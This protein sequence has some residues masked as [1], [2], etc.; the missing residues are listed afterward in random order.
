[1]KCLAVLPFL[2]FLIGA[3]ILLCQSTDATISGIVFDPSSRAISNAQVLILNEATGVRYSGT[4]NTVGLYTVSILPPGQYRIQVSKDG[5][6]TIIKP[7][8]I[9]NVQ[10]AVVLNFTLPVGATSESITVD[11][12]TSLLNTTD[13]SVSTVVD[14]QFVENIPLNGRSFQDLISMAPGVVTQ[15]PQSGSTLGANGDFSVNGQRTESNNYMVDGVTG[16]T[17]PG[18]GYGGYGAGTSGSLGGATALGTTQ[19]LISVDGLQEFRVQTST[20]SAEF[21]R[22]P[23]GQFSLV[24]R[25]GSEEFHGEVFDYLRNNFFD[26][27]DWFNDH[28]GDPI[29]A[30]R[31]NDFGGTF[32]G[33]IQIGRKYKANQSFFFVSYEGLRLTQP[34]AATIQYVP[35]LFMR[36]QSPSSMQGILN[37]FPIPN[38]ADYGDSANPSLAEFIEAYSSPSSID[39]TSLRIDHAFGPAFSV[40]GRMG[41]TPSM[42]SSRNDF[43][44]NTTQ[45]RVTTATFGVTNQFT[46]QISNEFRLGYNSAKSAVTDQ[47][48]TFGGATPTNLASA[49]GAGAVSRP[50]SLVELSIA[51]VGTTNLIAA[52]DVHNQGEQWNLVDTFRLHTGHQQFAFGVDYRRIASPSFPPNVQTA[53]FFSDESVL[54]STA[55]LLIA[56]NFFPASP[57]FKELSLFAQDEWRPTSRLSLSLGLRW[58]LNPPP[59]EAHGNDAYTLLGSVYEPTSLELAP[60]GTPL[61]KTTWYNLAPRLGLAWTVRQTPGRETVLRTGG[62]VF[63]DTNNQVAANGY[64]GIGFEASG[65]NFAAL[66]PVPAATFSQTPTTTAPYASD[67]IYAFPAHL[68]LPYTL[69][70]NA[71]LEQ[72]LGKHNAMTLSYIG[73]NGRRLTGEQELSLGS[74]NPNFGTVF[75]FNGGITSNYQALQSQFQRTLNHGLQ[76]LASYTWSHSLD[77]GSNSTALPLERGN[78]DFDVRNSFQGAVSWEIPRFTTHET[79]LYSGWALDGRILTRSGFPITLGGNQII[80]PGTGSTY[81]GGLNLIPQEPIY[82]HGSQYPGGRA[83]NRAAFNIPS[84]RVQG[85]A[86]RNFVRGFGESQIN[87]AARKQLHLRAG[88]DLQF[89]AETFNVLNHPNFGYVEPQATSE[90]PCRHTIKSEH[91]RCGIDFVGRWKCLLTGR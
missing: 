66:I 29:Q 7:G 85:N 71:S 87:L 40:F 31:Q 65:L 59:T 82:L 54:S 22:S 19:S 1:M 75:Y 49:L 38:G 44:V 10:A 55:D 53:L 21:G 11:A 39:S 4:T 80:D 32:G 57:I 17:N 64:E 20:Y 9:L 35:D 73:A 61:W 84:G 67:V 48:D 51:G 3:P 52:S 74:L 72:A 69:E 5:F 90:S 70:W 79:R 27:N 18:A 16:N 12:G 33:P 30:L 2:L 50:D 26:S 43:A 47:L 41:Y 25:S 62:G 81:S 88:V 68:Q 45:A 46:H 76:V 15:S 83:I 14:R 63:F 86:P 78:S 89:G 77:Y 34:Q 37:A 13:A 8:I 58:E 6:K 56:R 28:Y 36:Q 60:Q 42:T 23:G 24:T 91:H